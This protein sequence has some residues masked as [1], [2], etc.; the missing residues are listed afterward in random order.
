M[1]ILLDKPGQ[2][3]VEMNFET[4]GTPQQ[5]WAAMATGPGNAAWFARATIEE[6][7]GGQLRFDFMPGM[8]SQGEVTAWDPPHRFAYVEP[9][10]EPGA[11][12]IETEITLRPGDG[13]GSAVRMTHTIRTDS[14]R[15][16][17][18]LQNFE[19]N[20]PGFFKVLRNYLGHHADRPAASFQVMT[21]TSDA[22]EAVWARMT[23]A[24]GLVDAKPGEKRRVTG[25]Q[26]LSGTVEELFLEQPVGVAWVGSW[27]HAGS[28]VTASAAF[29]FYGDDAQ[30]TVASA[31]SAWQDWLAET[32][33]KR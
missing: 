33:A 12:P 27:R 14:S 19:D 30:D 13:S 18:S 4:P 23:G 31:E 24:L 22:L 5:A 1:P 21:Q 7:V 15:W 9:E 6:R 8:S 26:V 2:R 28:P 32:A 11:P 16:D 20:W 10:W 3:R 29:Y 17:A 25:P